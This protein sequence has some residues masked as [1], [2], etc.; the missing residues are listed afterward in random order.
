MGEGMEG[1]LQLKPTTFSH[2]KRV[3]RTGLRAL[4]ECTHFP[5]SAIMQSEGHLRC[6]RKALGGAGGRMARPDLPHLILGLKSE[7]D[8]EPLPS[9]V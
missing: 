6:A 7:G 8:P 3:A 1:V 9:K 5:S 2:A 4:G